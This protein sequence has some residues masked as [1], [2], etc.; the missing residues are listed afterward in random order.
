MTGTD[1]AQEYGTDLFDGADE[2]FVSGDSFI[3]NSKTLEMVF[4]ARM[5]V[6]VQV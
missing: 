3:P 2:V 5:F 4:K 6:E 1:H